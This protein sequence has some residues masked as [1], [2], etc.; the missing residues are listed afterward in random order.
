MAADSLVVHRVKEC[1]VRLHSCVQKWQQLSSRGLDVASKLV[2]TVMQNKYMESES[3]FG[4]LQGDST[5]PSVLEGKLMVE[6]E[7]L[8]SQLVDVKDK[9]LVVVQE[10]GRLTGSVSGAVELLLCQGQDPSLPLFNTLPAS[11]Y[12]RSHLVH[13]IWKNVTNTAAFM[14]LLQL[15]MF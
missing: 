4:V 6:R 8:Y 5:L 1:C 10:M 7:R 14:K 13:E 12:S 11:V 3:S 9:M 15:H 2:Q